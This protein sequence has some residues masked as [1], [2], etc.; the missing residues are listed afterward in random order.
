LGIGFSGAAAKQGVM[1]A[2][3][4]AK[5]DIGHCLRAERTVMLLRH[6]VTR[7]TVPALS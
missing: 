4:N 1:I 5:I 2:R 6:L 7:C 3:S